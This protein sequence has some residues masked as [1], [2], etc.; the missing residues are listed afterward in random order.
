MRF[1][2]KI[3]TVL[4]AWLLLLGCAFT[5]FA[6][7][8]SSPISKVLW[9]PEHQH[10][11]DMIMAI[12]KGLANIEN[13]TDLNTGG[14]FPCTDLDIKAKCF[15]RLSIEEKIN[16]ICKL[17]PERA[18]S[19]TVALYQVDY[20]S[21][22]HLNI[23]IF[24]FDGAHTHQIKNIPLNLTYFKDNNADTRE[25]AANI[26]QE[27]NAKH[28]HQVDNIIDNFGGMI[29]FSNHLSTGQIDELSDLITNQPF[30]V[31][32]DLTQT[33]SLSFV[34]DKQFDVNKFT[35]LMHGNGFKDL[36]IVAKG[37][38]VYQVVDKKEIQIVRFL[39][40]LFFIGSLIALA[41]FMYLYPER[42]K[43]YRLR[44]LARQR[45]T[46]EWIRLYGKSP[47]VGEPFAS[48][49]EEFEELQR[50]A[51]DLWD[52]LLNSLNQNSIP[53]KSE[54]KEQLT[55][56]K[57]L[58]DTAAACQLFDNRNHVIELKERWRKLATEMPV[59]MDRVSTCLK[60]IK[61]LANKVGEECFSYELASI[62]APETGSIKR[63][64]WSF[65]F[66]WIAI[67]L[68]VAVPS[69]FAVASY[70][71]LKSFNPL[72]REDVKAQL[73]AHSDISG[74]VTNHHY[75][76]CI[77]SGA[78]EPPPWVNEKTYQ[79]NLERVC[80]A[81][82][83]NDL[84]GPVKGLSLAEIKSFMAW[85]N[86][87]GDRVSLLSES[88]QVN[89]LTAQNQDHSGQCE[90]YEIRAGDFY[91]EGDLDAVFRFKKVL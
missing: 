60:D 84:S 83:A 70:R 71:G 46:T 24:I 53:S 35:V 91:T 55:N 32:Q 12:G 30:Y 86:R 65:P 66:K 28:R 45:K 37:P 69:Y 74:L 44:E 89:E 76:S 21:H 14:S 34:V 90:Y 31:G 29:R 10:S 8:A 67:S 47:S 13:G 85:L 18:C 36:S 43:V 38:K 16:T 75:L 5:T 19:D 72:D 22:K 25:I 81:E 57:Q 77:H 6:A 40:L 59:D 15:S 64:R 17:D 63:A 26:I 23:K 7:E 73:F 27:Y 61:N 9:L 50:Q 1:E 54:L 88:E 33:Q 51:S 80:G 49:V 82:Q 11:T 58:D 3:K 62:N 87:K 78:C 20:T 56:V 4:N 79:I 48:R 41:S 68:V 39:F 2:I 42:Y 52:I